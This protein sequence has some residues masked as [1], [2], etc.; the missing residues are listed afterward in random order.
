MKVVHITPTYFDESSIIG[1]GERYPTELA[2]WMSK[3]V[4]T[5][6]VSFLLPASL[7]TKVILQLRYIQPSI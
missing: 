7:T 3:V 2:S 1:G 5:T 6:L 4:D